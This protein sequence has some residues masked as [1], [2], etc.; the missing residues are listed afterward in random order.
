MKKVRATV[1]TGV[2]S[3]G[4]VVGLA[5]FAGATTGTIDTT[6]PDSTNKIEQNSSWRTKVR[7]TNRVE[8]TNTNDQDASSGE[9]RVR[10]NTTGGDAVSGDASNAN[11]TNASVSVDNSGGGGWSMPT[12][13]TSSAT[14]ENTGPDSY[15]KVESN[16]EA[17]LEVS[18]YNH[19]EVSNTNNQ[20]ATTGDATVSH[21]TTGGDAMSGSASNTNSTTMSFSINN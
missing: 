1:T 5:G 3:L 6:G 12:A 19:V 20:T 9:A 7:N 18:N 10:D 8:A 11:T 4:L 21:N 13:S 16:S 2:A 15:N 14:I 17:S